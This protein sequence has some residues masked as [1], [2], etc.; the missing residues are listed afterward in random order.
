[1]YKQNWLK[2]Y[3]ITSQTVT[4][5]Y[6]V[7]GKICYATTVSLCKKL[8]LIGWGGPRPSRQRRF[9]KFSATW[10]ILSKPLCTSLP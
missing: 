9:P 8:F 4:G 6:N 10:G 3:R 1:M 7:G 5:R 2:I